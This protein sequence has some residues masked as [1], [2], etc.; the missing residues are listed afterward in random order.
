[1]AKL[2]VLIADRE[3]LISGQ[4]A[5]TVKMQYVTLPLERMPPMR[6]IALACLLALLSGCAVVALPFRVTGDVLDVVPVVGPI[7]AAPF[8]ATADVID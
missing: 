2:A 7:A 8:K 6:W 5:V 4:K 3:N 1:V